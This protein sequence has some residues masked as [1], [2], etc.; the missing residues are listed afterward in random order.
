MQLLKKLTTTTI[1]MTMIQKHITCISSALVNSEIKNQFQNQT[2]AHFKSLG[3][4]Q[5]KLIVVNEIHF[6]KVICV[7]H[8]SSATQ[9]LSFSKT[10]PQSTG[11]T[12]F[13]THFTR[14]CSKLCRCSNISNDW[15]A[16]L[17]MSVPVKKCSKSIKW[18]SIW[19][20]AKAGVAPEKL[21]LK[22]KRNA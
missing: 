22:Q 12:N 6:Y 7:L 11:Y 20:P 16:N 13:L 1:T 14:Q 19:D 18:F 8:F 9:T 4:G 21:L 17:L 15:F 3:C 5:Y 2:A 10:V